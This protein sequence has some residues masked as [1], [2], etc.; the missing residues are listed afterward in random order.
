MAAALLSSLFDEENATRLSHTVLIECARF[1]FV[2]L[3]SI[4]WFLSAINRL[5]D[6]LI[7]DGDFLVLV[8]ETL[9]VQPTLV[10]GQMLDIA[11]LSL[12]HRGEEHKL[13][14]LIP[15]M[16]IKYPATRL[17]VYAALLHSAHYLEVAL[18][19]RVPIA[20]AKDMIESVFYGGNYDEKLIL[21]GKHGLV[22]DGGWA[23]C[24]MLK[25]GMLYDIDF[26]TSTVL[27]L[28]QMGSDIALGN[29]PDK[30]IKCVDVHFCTA[31]RKPQTEDNM[32]SH[33]GGCGLVAYC[34]QDCQKAHWAKHKVQEKKNP[35][36]VRFK[37]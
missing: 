7:S 2:N 26:G 33:C 36:T 24:E 28:I 5:A 23:V 30:A 1:P 6:P 17:T 15:A 20:P 29:D 9:M 21:L 13:S 34:G 8:N 18:K 14:M 31:C 16:I 37:I 4:M 35:T 32:L 10:F 3:F 25:H 19:H 22:L 12:I 11:A 27:L